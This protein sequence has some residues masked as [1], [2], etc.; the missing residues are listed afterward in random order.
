MRNTEDP[1]G[2]VYGV[3]VHVSNAGHRPIQI[4]SYELSD[5]HNDVVDIAAS[6]IRE[7]AVTLSDGQGMDCSFDLDDLQDASQHSQTL[8]EIFKVTDARG[9]VYALEL[10]GWVS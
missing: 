4:R 3:V 6:G 1:T 2:E 10:P 9:N 8:P 5:R 7:W